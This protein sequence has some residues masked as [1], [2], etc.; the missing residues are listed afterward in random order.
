MIGTIYINGVIGQDTTLI[1]V[2]RQVKATKGTTEYLVKIDSVGGYVDAGKAIYDYLK[3]LD[4]PVTTYTT[5]A[6][7]ILSFGG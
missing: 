7:S 5:K 2:I 1:D 6:F 3:G 4:K